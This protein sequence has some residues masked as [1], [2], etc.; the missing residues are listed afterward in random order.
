MTFQVYSIIIINIIFPE[1][2]GNTSIHVQSLY[3]DLV[4]MYYTIITFCRY[5]SDKRHWYH[6]NYLYKCLNLNLNLYVSLLVLCNVCV[7]VYFIYKIHIK[8]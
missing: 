7:C 4:E 2:L 5:T 1:L 8:I 6:L 3:K